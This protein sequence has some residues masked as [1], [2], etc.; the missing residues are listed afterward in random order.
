MVYIRLST[1]YCELRFITNYL[2]LVK[3]LILKSNELLTFHAL[4]YIRRLN[5]V[6]GKIYLLRR[7]CTVSSDFALLA[8]CDKRPTADRC[9]RKF[10]VRVADAG[11]IICKL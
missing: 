9:V 5:L 7:R 1:G 4:R 3:S 8:A 10:T 11:I 2:P 6:V